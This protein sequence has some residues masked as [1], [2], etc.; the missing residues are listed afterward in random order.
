[1]KKAQITIFIILGIIILIAIGFGI[2]LAA[3]TQISAKTPGTEHALKTYVEDCLK[4][5]A[6]TALKKIGDNG[7]FLEFKNPYRELQL[8]TE[9]AEGDALPISE[10]GTYA[11]PY[12]WYMKT[13]NNCNNCYITSDNMPLIPEIE[14]QINNYITNN[15]H[16]CL[17]KFEPFSQMQIKTGEIAV[18]TLTTDNEIKISS[19]YP[20][21]ASR[22]GTTIKI[23]DFEAT[24]NIKL[25]KIIELANKIIEI[26]KQ[27]SAIEQKIMHMLS[28]H[29]GASYDTLP[30]ISEIT[31]DYYLITWTK[32]MAEMQIKQI[33]N[34]YTPLLRYSGTK[35]A[36]DIKGEKY[37]KG[38]YNA[39]QISMNKKY[40][41]ALDISYNNWPIYFEISPKP[42]TGTYHKQTFPYDL[43]PPFQT[44]TYEFYY[45]LS[46]PLLFQI[47][48]PEALKGEGYTM[49]FAIEANIRD[50]KDPTKWNKGEGTLGPW[51]PEKTTATISTTERKQGQCTKI[52]QQYKCSL[53]NQ[54]Y[55]T[56]QQCNE[57]CYTTEQK[58][59]EPKIP[60][61]KFC[62]QAQKISGEISII[63]NTP[64]AGISYSCG[65]YKTCSQG[66]TN[67]N[68]SAAIK[69]PIC[70]GGILS[71]YKQGY[72]TAKIPLST[73][74]NK[75]EKIEIKLQKQK[76]TSIGCKKI[77]IN[78][79][80]TP[81]G[82]EPIISSK[83]TSLRADQK[84]IL[85][86]E[87]IPEKTTD[88]PFIQAIPIEE[89]STIQ[90]IPGKYK[91]KITYIDET[92]IIIPKKCKKICIEETDEIK[93]CRTACEQQK[94]FTETNC[95]TAFAVNPEWCENTD[96]ALKKCKE[97]C[98]KEKCKEWLELP[99]EDLQIKPA[100]MGGAE[101]NWTITQAQL[102]NAEHITFYILEMP[103][104]TCLDQDCRYAP[105]IGIDEMGKTKEYSQRFREEIEPKIN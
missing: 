87:K 39:M 3:K 12:W 1:M 5:T 4:Q 93:A 17:N 59:A 62:D 53:N 36:K 73:Q 63:T 71:I 84:A 30:P 10:L 81:T 19:E 32:E 47:R 41:L 46:I 8:K 54:K 43:I 96:F 86:I 13:P 74:T 25:K 58:K 24:I 57:I 28:I 83:K 101:L 56:I 102:E 69:L 2:Y 22:Q 16:T 29:M 37:E 55:D 100:L 18:K 82:L 14:E 61:T 77:K 103:T 97:E 44:N 64:D 70:H 88:A 52:N 104:P 66:K 26:Q 7:G 15:I 79:R 50:N 45:D 9:P 72:Y 68:G 60:K 95:K 105:C 6:I 67:T 23:K 80:E 98:N 48:D 89:K 35:N 33:L 11:V 91:I 78:A 27:D 85:K 75:K 42:I 21:E 38:F 76:E 65:N 20:I 31:H 90:L 99:E 34:S 49:N 40:D 51:S 94:D 92:G